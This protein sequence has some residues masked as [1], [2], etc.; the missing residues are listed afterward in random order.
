M[1]V[2]TSEGPIRGGRRR[3]SSECT[4]VSC[5]EI[6][7]IL[8]RSK[9]AVDKAR[10]AEHPVTRR[11]PRE[12]SPSHKRNKIIARKIGSFLGAEA[13]KSKPPSLRFGAPDRF[14]TSLFCAST[15]IYYKDEDDSL[16]S[17]SG[18]RRKAAA[19]SSVACATIG[20]LYW[21]G[22]GRGRGRSPSCPPRNSGLALR[23]C[24]HRREGHSAQS[25]FA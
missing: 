15:T 8:L 18:F 12:F 11:R 17:G 14:A 24:L 4:L 22:N 6:A 1:L 9:W 23:V 10:G 3:P 2:W 7:C 20:A 13:N 16:I 19:F 5:P 21:S 25:R